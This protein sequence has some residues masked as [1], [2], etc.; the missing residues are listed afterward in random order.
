MRRGVTAGPAPGFMKAP[1]FWGCRMNKLTNPQCSLPS[2]PTCG[3]ADVSDAS[4][5]EEEGVTA[6]GSCGLPA[7]W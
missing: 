2:H 5:C 1:Y 6:N 3:S 4:E 7:S